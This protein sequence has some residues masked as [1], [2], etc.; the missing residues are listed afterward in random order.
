MKFNTHAPTEVELEHQFALDNPGV[1]L[2]K[3][4][5]V[6]RMLALENRQ[7]LYV[8][9]RLGRI[10]PPDVIIGSGPAAIRRWL[11]ATVFAFIHKNRKERAA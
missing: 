5:D 1:E 8:Q 4:D 7:S 6:V 10:P 9:V 3:P 11:P 2:M